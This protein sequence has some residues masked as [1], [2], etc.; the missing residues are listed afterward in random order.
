MAAGGGRPAPR[1]NTAVGDVDFAIVDAASNEA[2]GALTQ[3][4]DELDRRFPLGF[5]PGDAVDDAAVQL[6]PPH[7]L[8]LVAGRDGV[9][10]GCGALSFLDDDT[11]EIKRMWINPQSRG[12]GLGTRLL[13]RLEDE[14]RRAGRTNIVLDTNGTLTEA[15]AMYRAS[16][17]VDVDAYNDNPYADHWF[18]KTLSESPPVS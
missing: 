13:S 8:F 5:E 4:F 14:S 2:R 16:G 7:G 6:N 15:I 11:A 1:L 18:A 9:T 10:L 17:Y 12:L 3:Y